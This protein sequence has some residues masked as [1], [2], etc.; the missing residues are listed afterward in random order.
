M[1]TKPASLPAADSLLIDS[2]AEK[3]Q[4]GQIARNKVLECSPDTPLYEA[5]RLMCER[6]VSSILIVQNG[7]VLGIWTERDTLKLSLDQP[8]Q[9][10]MPV[11]S[12]M[13]SPVKTVP[14][15]LNLQELAVRFQEESIRHYLVVDEQG[16]RLGLVSQTDVVV[17]QG[18]EHYLRLRSVDSILR[19][20]LQQLAEQA[21]PADAIQLM[22][23]A[24]TDAV[25]VRYTNGDWGIITERDLV[26]YIAHPGQ[27]P[28]AGQIASRPLVTVQAN[29][30]LYQVRNMLINKG[31]R[32]VGVTGTDNCLTSII[33]F[34]D[35]LGSMELSYI[36]E[37]QQ[38]LR[39]RD[40]ELSLSLTHLRLAEQVIES[41]LE[42]IM[43]TDLNS[44][45]ISVNPA[46]SRLTGYSAAEVIGKTPDILSSG[47]HDADFY[48]RM[49]QQIH[50]T[51]NWQGEVWNKRKNGEIYPE[52]L[53]ITT[54][55]SPEGKATHYAALFNDISMQKQNEE[56]IRQLAYYDS[57]TGLPNRRLFID[58]MELAIAHAKRQ[59]QQLAVLFIDLDHFKRINDSLGHAAGDQFLR[60]VASRLQSAVRAHDTI[61][62]VGGD[63]FIA[64]LTDIGSPAQAM[65]T[66]LRMLEA[67]SP[68]IKYQQHELVV[69]C[70]IGASIYPDDGQNAAV[71]LGHADTAMYRAKGSGRNAVQF[72]TDVMNQHSMQ[73]LAL[74]N[75]LHLA[76]ENS[77]F[78]LYY[79]PIVQAHTHRIFSAEALLRWRHPQRGIIPPS[80]FL[81][82]A[83]KLNLMSR[84][85]NWVITTACQQLADWHAAGHSS[86]RISINMSD[87]H[88][89]Q[90]D[91]LQQ[92]GDCLDHTGCNP[93]YVTL[94]LTERMLMDHHEETMERLTAVHRM[95]FS[96]AL[97]D[98]G[99]GWSSLSHLRHYSL[100][101]LKI[102]REFVQDILKSASPDA[103]I[104][105]AVIDLSH[106]LKLRVVA[107][108]I[109]T[110]EQLH[111][112]EAL[113]CDLI[114]GYYFSPPVS[115]ADFVKLL[116]SDA[117]PKLQG[118]HHP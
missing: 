63:E 101:E 49:W 90:A 58:R 118:S 80:E 79:Q 65:Q 27:Q 60:A 17:N 98:F 44:K 85:S 54:L 72:Y 88:F 102:D 37:L 100:D 13:S 62:R 82:L 66:A 20:G 99:T 70:T 42:G 40:A 10:Q 91:F 108:G 117:L 29:A 45:I 18:I 8:E 7:Q 30:S 92:L 77:E 11:S 83:E 109:E 3:I 21:S 2:G 53:T 1:P 51:G 23:T 47:Q 74:E 36:Q 96:L 105:E 107:E 9:L 89:Y 34:R 14:A 81:P 26:R 97:D 39:E 86:L 111:Q 25:A 48:A 93:G 61:A 15:S 73:Q 43:V 28:N 57:L 113:G 31:Y 75:A 41:S 6:K 69:S 55:A 76:V 103:A 52:L 106:K 67:L 33:S 112:L 22:R 59:G 16:K 78:E 68:P 32:H 12:M 24:R 4:A 19:R 104:I 110:P 64:L 94:E 5:A 84:L 35:I 56:R 116:H 114:Q 38:A 115:A 50:Q 46:F 87:R 95:G 71:L